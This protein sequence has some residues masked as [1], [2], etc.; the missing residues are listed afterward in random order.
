MIVVVAVW[1]PGRRAAGSAESDKVSQDLVPLSRGPGF[2]KRAGV[3]AETSPS[4]LWSGQAGRRASAEEADMSGPF[5][6]ARHAPSRHREHQ[7]ISRTSNTMGQRPCVREQP[8]ATGL[9]GHDGL[10]PTD[11]FTARSPRISKWPPTCAS[12]VPHRVRVASLPPGV[13]GC[14]IAQVSAS[15][16]RAYLIHGPADYLYVNARRSSWQ[17]P[18][19][20]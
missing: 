7:D 18:S 20:Q 19:I 6:I 15:I 3:P 10:H 2:Q 11:G 9:T 13:H 1:P 12:T 17:G 4:R 16:P 5:P 14:R 8:E